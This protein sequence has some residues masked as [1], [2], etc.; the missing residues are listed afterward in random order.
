V[1]WKVIDGNET[2]SFTIEHY[3]DS[4]DTLDATTFELY[5]NGEILTLMINSTPINPSQSTSYAVSD[6][7]TFQL[8]WK[9]IICGILYAIS[10]SKRRMWILLTVTLFLYANSVFGTCN[11]SIVITIQVPSRDLQICLDVCYSTSGTKY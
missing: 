2:I 1:K 4:F 11:E 5:T 6:S 8:D 3:A 7:R 9:I 10:A